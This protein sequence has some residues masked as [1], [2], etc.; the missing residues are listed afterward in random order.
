[1]KV[2]SVLMGAILLAIFVLM[3]AISFTYPEAARFQPL[4]IGLPAVA[5]CIL[6]IALDIA[7][8]NKAPAAA[9]GG[10]EFAKAE[11]D[12]ARAT[13]REIHF[14]VA[15]E[16]VPP[17]ETVASE[18]GELRREIIV[19]A[20][21][22]GFVGSIIAF[23]F[24]FSI[25]LFLFSF[26]AI[27]GEIKWPKAVL[28]AAIGTGVFFSIFEIA[29]KVKVFEGFYGPWIWDQIVAAIRASGLPIRI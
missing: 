11:A 22:L 12:L 3:L 4:V 23:G 28:M 27:Q 1:M 29:L 17:Q 19:W 13:G 25:P 8:R 10:N 14:E 15:H 21:F 26:L 6:Q 7:H 5:L 16:Q 20:F 24:W 9:D 18:D 2:P